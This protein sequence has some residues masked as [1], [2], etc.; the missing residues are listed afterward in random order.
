MNYIDDLHYGLP[1]QMRNYMVY[2]SSK[3]HELDDLFDAKVQL[4]P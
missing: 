4:L 1:W 2:R 3:D